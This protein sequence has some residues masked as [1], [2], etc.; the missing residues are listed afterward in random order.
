V[1]TTIQIKVFENKMQYIVRYI[2]TL[3][4]DDII[5][6]ESIICFAFA[7]WHYEHKTT[8]EL[9]KQAMTI[10]GPFAQL[11]GQLQTVIF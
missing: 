1:P 6:Y 10:V 8:R 3:K 11:Y 9:C 7:S 2:K 4:R 5:T